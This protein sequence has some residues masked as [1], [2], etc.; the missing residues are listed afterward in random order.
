MPA[1]FFCSNAQCLLAAGTAALAAGYAIYYNTLAR[2]PVLYFNE[3]PE[4]VRLVKGCPALNETYYPTFWAANPH[5]ATIAGSLWRNQPSLEYR[6]EK[7]MVDDEGGVLYI[8]WCDQDLL[9]PKKAGKASA[10]SS[11]CNRTTSP[12]VLPYDGTPVV[13][14]LSGLN[15]SSSS[16]YVQH[17]ILQLQMDHG[18]ACVAMNNRGSGNTQL[19]SPKNYCGAFTE[20]IRRVVRHLKTLLPTSPIFLVG[21]SLGANLLVKYLGEEGRDCVVAGA[22]SVCNPFDFN[23]SATV[24]ERGIGRL[25][26]KVFHSDCIK[27]ILPNLP[28]FSDIPGMDIE[29]VLSTSTLREFDES[30]TRRV[31]GFRSVDHYYTEASSRQYIPKVGV[32][33]LLISAENDPITSS[34]ALPVTE[35]KQNEHTVLAVTAT[36]GH[37]GHLEGWNPFN[38][39]IWTD[40]LTSQY[41][42]QLY[43]RFNQQLEKNR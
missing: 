37:L 34:T 31:F 12:V 16:P 39:G 3:T 19:S 38:A 9:S 25:Y 42:G 22:V 14:V 11:S 30:F 7:V 20:D 1:P 41:L 40:R 28:M 18:F 13:L 26:N 17:L 23:M 21:F 33:L 6:R 29:K 24:L 10:V 4:N 27:T 15:G 36:G 8:D 35:C 32:P 5:L 43:A 2:K